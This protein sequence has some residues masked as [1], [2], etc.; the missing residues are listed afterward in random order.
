MKMKIEKMLH[1]NSE[2]GVIVQQ[3]DITI[4]GYTQLKWLRGIWMLAA[5]FWKSKRIMII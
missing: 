1:N 4:I 3:I 2:F 5:R